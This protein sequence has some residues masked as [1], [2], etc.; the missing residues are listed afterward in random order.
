LTESQGVNWSDSETRQRVYEHVVEPRVLQQLPDYA[1]VLT[2][3]APGGLIV[4]GV[5]VDPGIA[6]LVEAHRNAADIAVPAPD[7]VVGVDP[8]PE[9][10]QIESAGRLGTTFWQAAADQAAALLDRVRSGRRR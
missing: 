6:L 8:V 10:L 2:A 4:R 3:H 9:R 1:M 5:E 7:M